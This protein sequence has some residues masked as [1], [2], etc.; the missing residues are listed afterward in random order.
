MKSMTAYASLQISLGLKRYRLE[1]QTL[2]KKG[3]DITLDIPTSF[4]SLSIPIRLC[5][6]KSIDRGS[7]W[8]RLKEDVQK[9]SLF[10]AD[11][12]KKLKTQL[13]LVAKNLGYD[14]TSISF[15]FLLEKLHLLNHEQDAAFET[16]EPFIQKT[17]ISL[18]EMREQ[19]GKRLKT[20]ILARLEEILTVV[21]EIEELEIKSPEITKQ[22]LKERLKTLG[23][24]NAEDERFFKEVVYFV[25]RQDVS[26]EI[27]RLKSHI[28]QFRIDLEKNEPIG[29]RLEFLVQECFREANTLSS[30]SSELSSVNLA[31]SIKNELEKIKEQVMNIE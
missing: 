11:N 9:D 2:N 21:S 6:S 5:L 31:L 12:L 10:D 23:L 15:P 22:K 24:E 16:I 3:L 19:E 8:F 27:V 14:N 7:V 25:D 28:A 20:D 18:S 4:Y 29:R 13:E 1:I 30:K 26:E 17:L